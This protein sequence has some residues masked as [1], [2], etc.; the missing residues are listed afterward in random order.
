MIVLTTTLEHNEVIAKR[1]YFAKWLHYC[2]F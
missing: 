1:D 2:R